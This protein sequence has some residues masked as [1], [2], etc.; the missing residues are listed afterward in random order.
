MFLLPLQ[1]LKQDISSF[2]FEVLGL[3]KGNKLA[4][5]TSTEVSSLTES[6]EGSESGGNE[7]IMKKNLSLF[8]ITTMIHPRVVAKVSKAHN[9]SNGSAMMPT[10]STKD[11]QKKVSFVADV[12]KLR[13]F[14][15]HS[16]NSST[17]HST[18][19]IY[20]ISEEI[21]HQQA[22]KHKV[23]ELGDKS[24]AVNC[25]LN[26]H[27]LSAKYTVPSNK[28]GRKETFNSMLNKKTAPSGWKITKGQGSDFPREMLNNEQDISILKEETN[29]QSSYMTTRL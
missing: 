6:N 21:S 25:E 18:N 12:K 1:E 10:E 19:K 14:H 13:L 15:R 20:S 5:K 2:R 22:E 7:K 16:N 4:N 26:K 9:Q 24:L 29:I 23:I 28:Q 27:D 17:E 8:K 11:K 3:L